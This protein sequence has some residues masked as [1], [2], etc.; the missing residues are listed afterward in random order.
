MS[1]I[2]GSLNKS[3]NARDYHLD[4]PENPVVVYDT[5]RIKLRAGGKSPTFR[6][7]KLASGAQF[8]VLGYAAR[9]IGKSYFSIADTDW[10]SVLSDESGIKQLDGHFLIVI[11]TGRELRIFNDP[12]GKRDLYIMEDA[13][14]IFFTSSLS[15]LRKIKAPRIDFTGLGLHWHTRFP[16]SND[17]YSPG[18]SS[19]YRGVQNLGSGATAVLGNG[20]QITRN[21]LSPA[22]EHK[23]VYQLLE[24]FCLVPVSQS[25]RVAI[26][27]SGGM[28]VRPL[29]A[30]YLK[31]GVRL[32]AVHYGNED[33]MDSSIARQISSDHQIPFRHISYEEAEGSDS[34]EQAVEFME[35]RGFTANPANAPYQGYYRIVSEFADCFVSGFFGE[36]F[37]FR[38]FI[39]HLASILKLRKPA[40][41]DLAAY[42]Y[43]IPAPIFKPEI[44]AQLHRGFMNS[45]RESFDAMP[46]AGGMLN[47]LWFNLFLARYLPSTAVGTILADLDT[48]L[49]DHMPWLQAEIIRQHWQYGFGFQIAEGIHRNLLKR[50]FPALASYPLALADVSAPYYYR[51]YMLKLKMRSY[52][53]TRPL[54]SA[55]RLDRFLQTHKTQIND[56]FLSSRVQHNESY[57]LP[58]IETYINRYY[59]G[60][61]GYRNPVN[62]WLAFELGK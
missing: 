39:A 62:G 8:Y 42:L 52:Y 53:K 31:A 60:D 44:H 10:E 32:T 11:N 15:L 4:C 51:Q 49:L 48:V 41:Q 7:G 30:V 38:F 16:P 40:L 47:P 1:W 54:T 50:N 13:D 45:L 33:S 46:P 57:N 9:V 28:D 58:L 55:N 27:L 17:S 36:L 6:T 43:H 37:R 19:P 34:W 25:L 12:L 2:I 18:F 3:D 14:E 26:G 59:K 5:G 24:S 23:D 22:S 29:L 21:L 56:L 35:T 20:V 61:G